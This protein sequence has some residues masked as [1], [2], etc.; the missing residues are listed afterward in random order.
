M[1]CVRVPEDKTESAEER[2]VKVE[3]ASFIQ[4]HSS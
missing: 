1:I 4:F 2:Q 3:T